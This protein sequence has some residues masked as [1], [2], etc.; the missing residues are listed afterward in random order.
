MYLLIFIGFGASS[1]RKY[2]CVIRN[3]IVSNIV[4]DIVVDVLVYIIIN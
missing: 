2:S 1:R 4:V 3:V